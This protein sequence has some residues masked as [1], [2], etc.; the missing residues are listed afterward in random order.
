M[1]IRFK[2]TTSGC[3]KCV[4]VMAGHTMSEVRGDGSVRSANAAKHDNCSLPDHS[5]CAVY[6]FGN[7]SPDSIAPQAESPLTATQLAWHPCF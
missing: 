5:S 2:P 1:W 7:G 6:I 3:Q 4:L